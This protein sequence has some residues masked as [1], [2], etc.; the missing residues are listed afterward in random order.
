MGVGGSIK[1][2]NI[3]FRNMQFIKLVKKTAPMV[4]ILSLMVTVVSTTS[5][6]SA[7]EGN[8]GLVIPTVT[9][10]QVVTPTIDTNTTG[11]QNSSSETQTVVRKCK[12]NASA[13]SVETGASVT[14]IWETQG[15]D[16]ITINGE[17]VSG[18]NGSKTYNNIQ[19]NTTYNLVAET[20]DGSSNCSANVT[21]ACIP[22]VVIPDPTCTIDPVTKTINSG[23]STTIAWTTTNAK[24]ATL[25]DFN[26][27]EL[28]GN[29]N[30]G[31][32]TANKTYTLN[33]VGNNDKTVS[34][35]SNITVNTPTTPTNPIAP[36]C[37]FTAKSGRT[38]V[39]LTGKVLVSHVAIDAAQSAVKT[40]NL[41]SGKYDVSL[42]AW[43]GYNSRVSATQANE[44]YKLS[45]LNGTNVIVSSNPTSD[46]QDMVR[47]ATFNGK[48]NSALQVNQAV[49]GV[50]ADHAFHPNTVSPN[51]VH[52]ICAALDLISED[53]QPTPPACPY[54]AQA[55]RT[56]VTFE[57]R[58]LLSDRGLERTVSE[59]KP[60]NLAAGKYDVTLVAWDGYNSRVTT[61]QPS[62]AYFLSLTGANG[63]VKNSNATTDLQD[64]VREALF[65][66]KVNSSLVVESAITG[67]QAKHKE[68][69][70]TTVSPNSVNVV[71]AVLD[72]IP[73]PTV[74]PICESFTVSTS[75]ITKG[76]SAKL[77]WTTKNASRVTI[78]NGIGEVSLNGNMDVSPIANITYL[79]T[80]FGANDKRHTC[81][82]A[83]KVEE[84]VTPTPISCAANATFISDKS[85]I[86]EGESA[87]L[88]WT[89]KGGITGV[90]F[91]NGITNKDLNGS[92]VVTPTS[93]TTYNMTITDGKTS[94]SCPVA[95]TVETSG[96]GGGGGGSS[97]PRCELTASAK[98]IKAGSKVTLTWDTTRARDIIL[99]DEKNK[100][101]LSTEK[102]ETKDKDKHF[103][104]SMVV[105]PTKDMVY[106]LTVK[107]G[108]KERTCKV[109]ID[110]KDDVVVKEDRNQ[111]PLVTGISLTDV[112]YTGFTAGPILTL[113]FYIILLAWALYLAYI[114][115]I[116]RDA[117]GGYLL[118][119]STDNLPKL[120]PEAVRP[121]VF[122][123]VT[124]P[125]ASVVVP[126]NLPVATP[127]ATGYENHADY[128]NVAPVATTLSDEEVAMIEN[129][130]HDAHVLLSTDAVYYFASTTKSKEER[131]SAL[132]QVMTLAKEKYPAEDGWVVLNEK[133]MRELCVLCKA[134]DV[135]KVTEA[136]APVN[137]PS[138][139]SSLAEAI[140]I[141]NIV[142]AYE[143][144]GNRPMFALAE[145]ASDFDALYR[146]RRGETVAVSNLLVQETN[147]LSDE[148]IQT[149]ITALTGALDGT[150]NDEAS[151]VKMAIMK[152][153]K[154]VA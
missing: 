63:F 14:L 72:L 125:T 4:L 136:F 121:D 61:T 99:K 104:S 141:G 34:C 42:F 146:S 71:C 12:I 134:N 112:P 147:K 19:V 148:Q 144:I 49:T 120:S 93:N 126:S 78:D 44:Q 119:T 18:A 9:I 103:D 149:I 24:S 122:V 133:R 62:E 8:T 69:S 22:P 79:L 107:R 118:A 135:A 116:R 30:S 80:A 67:L 20:N 66:G 115:V 57:N 91:D 6:A 90:S 23:E 27:V 56:I 39:D 73:E 74:D 35:V 131:I 31:A 26:A 94:V 132:T 77:T 143:M 86:D 47:E 16:K 124:A 138:G 82:V 114:L 130:A 58:W 46:L 84:P 101:L 151:A 5:V 51:S 64:N 54:T 98:S 41:P 88:T 97:S 137:L 153:V 129:Q 96:G 108:S 102:M 70:G 127:V 139:S 140:A 81:T 145:A 59:V 21:V 92:V 53:P 28:N 123:N 2:M 83:L 43:D 65:N 75:T 25:T 152:A 1:I 154:V 3:K 52:P 15:F 105:T 10:P 50:R 32:L 128:V 76:G 113:L 117:V 29:R 48:V 87:T 38:I 60:I 142:S 55:N 106:T 36:S 89:T 150:Y 68:T 100:V 33:V 110:V 40:V 13:S 17:T 37:P 45:F 11:G 85:T 95:I 109:S 111:K 7:E